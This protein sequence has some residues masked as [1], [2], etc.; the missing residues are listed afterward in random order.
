MIY[1]HFVH[2]H[3][4]GGS[5]PEPAPECNPHPQQATNRGQLATL[6]SHQSGHNIPSA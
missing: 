2:S 4:M 3:F 6:P 5:H 1:V